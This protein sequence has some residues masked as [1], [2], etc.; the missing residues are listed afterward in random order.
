MSGPTH[1][2]R[3]YKVMKG[4]SLPEG[5]YII[6]E[7]NASNWNKDTQER[8]P[9]PGAKDIKM[10]DGKL[11]MDAFTASAIAQVYDK[12]NPTNKKKMEQLA[13]GK[14]ADLMKLQALAMKFVK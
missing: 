1:S 3:N 9:V 14:K 7:W 13:N 4:Y 6:E 12:V 2:N 5:E 11:K 10:K 8:E